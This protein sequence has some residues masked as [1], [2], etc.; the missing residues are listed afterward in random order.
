M[1][2]TKTQNGQIITTGKYEDGVEFIGIDEPS[3][4]SSIF[5]TILANVTETINFT[6]SGLCGIAVDRFFEREDTIKNGK[7]MNSKY[8]GIDAATGVEFP[9]GTK[10]YYYNK[11]AYIA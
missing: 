1:K 2:I 7:L 8:D 9:A 10:I 3:N 4:F 6:P 5:P 11:S